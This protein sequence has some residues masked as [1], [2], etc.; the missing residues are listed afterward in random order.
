MSKKFLQPAWSLIE[1]IVALAIFSLV[2][3]S[4]ISLSAG[5]L[6]PWINIGPSNRAEALAQEGL[7]AA[8][9]IK[10]RAWNEINFKFSGLS[11]TG[12][13]W[14]LT[15]EGTRENIN[16][17]TRFLNFVD[18]CRDAQDQI[19]ACPATRRDPHIKQVM[20]RVFWTVGSSVAKEITRTSYLTNWDSFFWEQTDWSGGDGQEI[21]NVA[22][23]FSTASNIDL[24]QNGQISLTKQDNGILYNF[25]GYLLSSAFP[26][27]VGSKVQVIEW[28][29]FIPSPAQTI[30][31]QVRTALDAGGVPG[32]WSQWFGKTGANDYFAD[33]QGNLIDKSLN[34]RFWVQYRVELTSDGFATPVLNKVKINYKTGQGGNFNNQQV[35]VLVVAGGGGGAGGGTSAGGG[36][37]GV[38]YNDVYSVPYGDTAVVVGNGGTAGATTGDPRGGNGGDSSFGTIKTSGGGGGGGGVTA[39]DNAYVNGKSGG[40][41]GGGGAWY[42]TGVGGLGITGQGYDGGSGQDTSPYKGGGGGG[43]GGIGGTPNGNVGGA[44]GLGLAYD[45]SGVPLYYAGG[46]G[47]GVN[48]VGIP[49]AGGSGV[50][51]NGTANSLGVPGNGLVNRGAG[52]GGAGGTTIRAGGAGGS[53]VVIISYPTGSIIAGGG[54]ITT[55]GGNTIHTFISSGTFTIASGRTAD[56][57]DLVL[58]GTPA[59]YTFSGSNYSYSNVSVGASVSSITVTPTGAGTITVEGTTVV[60]GQASGPISL[61]AGVEKTITVVATE[62]DK[63]A[64]TYIIYVTRQGPC[65]SPSRLVECTNTDVYGAI[66][67]G[68]FLYCRAGVSGCGDANLVASP[69]IDVNGACATTDGLTRSWKND[70]TTIIE[71]SPYTATSTY[72]GYS[73]LNGNLVPTTANY[74][75]SSV[76]AAAKFC[77][78]LVMNGFSDWYLPAPSEICGLFRSS[79][80]CESLIGYCNAGITPLNGCTN[81]SPL[82]GGMVFSG[83][84]SSKENTASMYTKMEPSYLYLNI[85]ATSKN[86]SLNVRCV[87]RF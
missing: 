53:G 67:G 57:T 69:P 58:S 76:Y 87:R 40:S 60:S 49:G 35:K 30:K 71:P 1:I 82:V 56:L 83:Y 2:T 32:I 48:G 22:N 66:C 68:G 7:E 10:N 18:V 14:S 50:G 9:S 70:G 84:V 74:N 43:A 79:N 23:R 65:D 26:A 61:A 81:I 54:I 31:F 55:S 19:A 27:G 13:I 46:G 72:V 59:N 86:S 28:D 20:V 44:G 41:G 5:S 64:K 21:W 16:G 37:G 25:N 75:P 6:N 8:R 80:Y 15:G 12:D 52:G 33:N 36:G 39:N 73:N 17:Y 34:G 47:G 85:T 77:A 29:Q 11:L 78:D 45:I 62:T 51:G 38:V 42:G 63:I 3:A 24:T 4:L